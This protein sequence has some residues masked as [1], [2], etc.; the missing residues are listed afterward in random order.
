MNIAIVEDQGSYAQLLSDYLLSE[1]I[2]RRVHCYKSG[3]EFLKKFE[4]VAIGMIFLDLNMADGNGFETLKEL[5]KRQV[6][7]PVTILSGELTK[8]VIAKLA[9]YRIVDIIDKMDGVGSLQRITEC[10]TQKKYAMDPEL[11]K[12]LK[13]L[14]KT[15]CS[16]SDKEMEIIRQTGLGYTTAQIADNLNGKVKGIEKAKSVIM[17]KTKQ[18]TFSAVIYH[19]WE[20]KYFFSDSKQSPLEDEEED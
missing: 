17:R 11:K 4:N 10:I 20:S 14:S 7:I 12:K 13:H 3:N 18:P 6:P 19:L 16:L 2:C 15:T 5:K 9:Q 8:G 1:G